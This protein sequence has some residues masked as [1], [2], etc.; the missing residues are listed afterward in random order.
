M[1]M[2]SSIFRYSV[3][4]AQIFN[5]NGHIWSSNTRYN[6]KFDNNKQKRS[7]KGTLLL[8]KIAQSKVHAFSPYLNLSSKA[9]TMNRLI[10]DVCPNHRVSE[11][12]PLSA[13]Q[14][15]YH[16]HVTKHCYCRKQ[17][18]AGNFETLK[19]IQ[20]QHLKCFHNFHKGF[21][22]TDQPYGTSF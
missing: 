20:K 22:F 18:D 17:R 14:S 11:D 5:Q 21:R 15:N 7:P 2:I 16:A 10:E 12:A 13:K 8:Y 4:W 6:S 9:E 3:V 19:Q 1:G